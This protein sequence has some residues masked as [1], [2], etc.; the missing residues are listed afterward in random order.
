M[1]GITKTFIIGYISDMK[2]AIS[3]AQDLFKSSES[4]THL[5]L[6]RLSQD[7][8]EHFFGDIRS[9]GAWCQ[10]PTAHYFMYSYRALVSNQLQLFGLSQGR[11]CS[12]PDP[13][14]E[15][16]SLLVSVG[17]DVGVGC[18]DASVDH[19]LEAQHWAE[20][21]NKLMDDTPNELRSNILYYMAGWAAR[22][23]KSD[24]AYI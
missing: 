4:H 13:V 6:H 7:P 9:R 22:Q 12:D 1:C 20:I 24:K 16:N 15:S 14:N 3:L 18:E 19:D 2:A 23:V 21:H 8:I 17:E 11:N 5:L 10:N